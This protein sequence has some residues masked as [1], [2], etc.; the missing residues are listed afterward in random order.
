MEKTDL[1][2]VKT[3]RIVQASLMELMSRKELSK[4]TVS[5]ICENAG[6]NRKTFYRHYRTTADVISELESDLLGEFSGVLK[7]SI[8][9]VE[10]TLRAISSAVEKRRGYFSRLLKHNPDLFTKG[11]IKAILCRMVSAALKNAGD[12]DDEQ[13]VLAAAEFSVSGVLSL[14]AAWFD[15]GCTG[16]LNFLTNVA[17]NMITRGLSAFTSEEKLAETGGNY[18]R[19]QDE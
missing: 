9:N 5:E 7:S 11:K 4:I 13:T 19:E 14:Y 12:I 18:E 3:K 16:D 8:L 1:R 15:G 6:I 2:V 10:A 17:V